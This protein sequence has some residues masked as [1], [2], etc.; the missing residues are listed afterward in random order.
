MAC[1]EYNGEEEEETEEERMPVLKN[2]TPN[3]NA[4][5]S[6]RIQRKAVSVGISNASD[7]LYRSSKREEESRCRNVTTT[8]KEKKR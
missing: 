4:V 5:S 3:R 2:K 7:W 6:S 1:T 8:R